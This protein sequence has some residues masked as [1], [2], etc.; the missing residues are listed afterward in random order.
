MNKDRISKKALNMK[1]KQEAQD[2][3]GKNRLG[4]ISCRRKEEQETKFKRMS[5]DKTQI[6]DG[7]L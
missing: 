2:Q 3:D 5:P 4:K 6:H 1:Q 7:A